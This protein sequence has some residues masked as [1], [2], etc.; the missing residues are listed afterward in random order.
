MKNIDVLKSFISAK[1][2]CKTQHLKNIQ[3]NKNGTLNVLYNYNAKIAVFMFNN[4]NKEYYIVINKK[5]LHYT[6]TTQII[7]NKLIALATENIIRIEYQEL[8]N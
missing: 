4:V 5:Y 1:N 3:V 7:I 8:Y 6:K 2:T